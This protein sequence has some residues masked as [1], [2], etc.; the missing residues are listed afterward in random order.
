MRYRALMA[1]RPPDE[2]PVQMA[3]RVPASRLM[4]VRVFCIARRDGILVLPAAGA[5]G[6]RASRGC[7]SH[8]HRRRQP[9]GQ[10]THSAGPVG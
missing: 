3:M 5:A 2:P 4:K 1:T 9:L 10:F 8:R 6:Q 7:V